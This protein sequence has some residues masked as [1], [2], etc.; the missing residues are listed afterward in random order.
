MLLPDSGVELDVLIPAVFTIVLEFDF[1]RA[2]VANLLDK[3]NHGF[4]E[5]GFSNAFHQGAN[6]EFQRK[7]PHFALCEKPKDLSIEPPMTTN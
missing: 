2:S 6:A 1:R 3:P 7:L 4:F 5:L